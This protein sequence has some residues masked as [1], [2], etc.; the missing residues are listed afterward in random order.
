MSTS[1]FAETH[2]LIAFLKKPIESDKFEQIV[3]F[4]N[5][6]P[7]KYALRVSPTI[8]TSCIKQFW[9]SAKVKIV[10]EDVR[11]QALVDRKK[12]IVNEV[13]IIC[14]LRLDDAEGT[15]CLPNAAIFEELARM[16]AKTIAWNEF[17]STMASAIIFLAN[18]QKFNFSMYIFKSML[19]NLEVERKHKSRRK[20]RKETEVPHIEP[21]AEESVPTPS[22]DPLPSGLGDQED[23]SKQ[24]RIAE[25]DDDEDLSLI[26][27]TTHD[28]GRMN[29]ENLFG[30]NDLD[31]DEVFVDVTTCENVEKVATVTENEIKAAKPKT[32]GVVIQ[33]PSEFR[34]TSSLQPLQLLQAKEKA[35]EKDEA[36]IA[37]IE[38]W[39]DVQAIIDADRRKYFVV[40]RAKEIRNKPPLKAQQRSLMCI[41]MKNMEGYK[42]KDFKEKSFDA[43]KKMFDKVYKRVNIFVDTNIEIVEK[44]L[45]KTQAE[46][47]EELKRCLEIVPE[48][49]D[50]VTIEATPLSFK[51]PT[52]VDYKIYREEKKSYF[53][54]IRAD[55]NTQNYLPF[56]KM[57]KNFNREDLEVLRSIV[58]TRFEKI[59]PIDDMDNLLFQ[60]LRTMFKHHVEYNILKYQQGSIKVLHWKLFDSC[61]VHCITT[62]NMVYYLIG[63]EDVPI[64]K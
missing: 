33:E 42:K 54:I 61:R 25:I 13:F 36:N 38:E 57:F 43:I 50:D 41:Y 10:N 48:D 3:D 27:E 62:K 30:V 20:Q 34:T 18:N 45:K 29:E 22:N 55:G 64:Y 8:Y 7:I 37:M 2:N 31:G 9:T 60:T 26:N 24:G 15:A 32:K 63:G 19:K 59:K 53:K 14:D 4:L 46:V 47:S 28:Q 21:Q 17:S 52:I 11:F 51:S 58:K 5:A 44:K 49:D 40:K 56:G 12:V 1:T 6:N 23:T 39:D 16:G 35:R